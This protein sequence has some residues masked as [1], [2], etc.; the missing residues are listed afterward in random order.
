M[1]NILVKKCISCGMAMTKPEE[2]GGGKLGNPSCVYCSNEDGSLKPRNTVREGMIQF[3]MSR[4]KYN[5][6]KAEQFVDD[7][8][9]KMPA[10]K[11]S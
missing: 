10:W 7:Y 3:W 4:E 6:T 8:M 1:V 11:S 5:R 9:S 2:F